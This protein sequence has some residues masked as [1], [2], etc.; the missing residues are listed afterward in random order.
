MRLMMIN[1]VLLLLGLAEVV[2]GALPHTTCKRSYEKIGGFAEVDDDTRALNTLLLSDTMATSD[3]NDGHILDWDE[4]EAS[5]HSLACRCAAKT[6]ERGWKVFGLQNFGECW[7]GPGAEQRYNM[8]GAGSPTYQYLKLP[9]KPCDKTLDQECTGGLNVNYIYR[10][11]G[12]PDINGGYASWSTWSKCSSPCGGGSKM[13]KRS[14]TSP[15]PEGKGRDCSQLGPNTQTMSCNIQSCPTTSPGAGDVD[16]GWSAWLPW[17]PCSVTCGGGSQIRKRTCTNPLPQGSGRVC[18]GKDEE[19]R[20]CSEHP[21]NPPCMKALDLGIILDGSGSVKQSN[22]QKALQFL[23]TLVSHLRVSPSGTHVGMITYNS[24]PTLEFTPAETHYHHLTPLKHRIG[25]VRYRGGWTFTDKALSLAGQSLFTTHGGDRRGVPNVLIVLTDGMTSSSSVPYPEVLKPLQ[26]KG[27]RILAVGIGVGVRYI[28]LLQIAMGDPHYVVQVPNFDAL[29]NKINTILDKTCKAQPP[30]APSPECLKKEPLGMS[31]GGIPSASITASSQLS[32]NNGPELARLNLK[33][34]GDK[35]G[36]WSAK[37]NDP[38]QWL[39]VDFEEP[40]K[41]TKITTQGREKGN[42]YMTSYWLSY[43]EDGEYFEA[44][45]VKE[46]IVIFKGNHDGT[47]EN[48]QELK[49]QVY[50]RYVRIHPKAWKGHISLRVEFYGCRTGFITPPVVPCFK[51]LGIEKGEILDSQITASSQ[52]SNQTGP[53]NARLYLH[54]EGAR[55]GGWVAKIND[56]DQWLQADLGPVTKVNI[57]ATQGRQDDRQWVKSYSVSFSQDGIFWEDYRQRNRTTIFS[58]NSDSHSVVHQVLNPPVYARHIRIHPRKWHQNIAMRMEFYG[59]RSGFAMPPSPSCVQPLGMMTGSIHNA[60]IT[61]SSYHDQQTQPFYARLRMP[62]SSWTA[63]TNDVGQWLRVNLDRVTKVT[64]IATQGSFNTD[65]WVTSYTLEYSLDGGHYYKYWYGRVFKGNDDRKSISGHVLQPILITKYL[66]LQ[67]KTWHGAISLRMELYGCQSE[68]TPPSPEECMKAFGLENGDVID[69]QI[70]ASSQ[71][72]ATS[73]PSQARL[74]L[75]PGPGK[76]GGWV[77]KDSNKDQWLAV[78]FLRIVKISRISS[79]GRQDEDQWVTSYGI[80]HSKDGISYKAYQDDKGREKILVG[81]VDRYEVVS[82]VL[83][84]PI[85]ARYIRIV[86]KTWYGRIAMRLDFYG[87]IPGETPVRPPINPPTHPPINPPTHPPINPPTHP[88]I[89]PP[90]HPPIHPPTTI[91]QT[92]ATNIDLG[93]L[94][95]RSGDV[96]YQDFQKAKQFVAKLVNKFHVSSYGTRVG[97]I[98]YSYYAR[99]LLKFA[100]TY[101]Q[102]PSSVKRLV[103]G[104]SYASG[105]TRTDKALIEANNFLFSHAGGDRPGIPNVLLVITNGNSSPYNIPYSVVLHPLNSKAV[106]VISVGMST[107]KQMPGLLNIAGHQ[108][109]NVLGI[110]DLNAVVS[111]ACSKVPTLAPRPLGCPGGWH[112]FRSNCYFF[113]HDNRGYSNWYASKERCRTLGGNLL[114]IQDNNEWLFVKSHLQPGPSAYG[115]PKQYFIGMNDNHWEGHWLWQ[116]GSPVYFF[117]WAGGE[118]DGGH[119]E[120]CGTMHANDGFYGDT[121]CTFH[122]GRFICKRPMTS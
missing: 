45:R 67:P 88:P 21:C 96:S 65:Q 31:N 95:D 93:I 116:D 11:K 3:V 58:G 122:H 81:N 73:G 85:T 121:A 27:V 115:V 117:K 90:T 9:L 51:R 91:P 86:P 99:G 6:R 76:A 59:C 7:S 63:K 32:K 61:A 48:P 47:S 66:R 17:S 13:R 44:Y 102:N 111:A 10:L 14:C 42:Q 50:A 60:H 64:R 20:A 52:Y 1:Q 119:H 40:V 55:K 92:C 113:H 24:I 109:Q 28:E 112:P 37:Y 46:K 103:S 54:A 101:Y 19:S 36:G 78:D 108:H 53:E 22:F 82:H 68:F 23:S 34:T 114:D 35:A 77:A 4:W 104:I 89:H 94:L 110:D 16:G 84:P 80:E 25:L 49:N 18:L 29:K 15:K 79:Q 41:I 98:P 56:A 8:H 57:I 39:Q 38:E 5:I 74:H 69:A 30:T 100:D 107:G 97:V 105:P 106:K 70:T 12:E 72:T 62:V 118:P 71:L 75:H 43:S 83:N 120:N 26:A 87:C 2:L 33:Q